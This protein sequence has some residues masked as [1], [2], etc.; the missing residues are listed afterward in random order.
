MVASLLLLTS[1]LLRPTEGACTDQR[2]C[3]RDYDATSRRYTAIYWGLTTVPRDIPR[4]ALELY[5]GHNA[6]ASLPTG[7]FSH[8]TQCRIVRLHDNKKRTVSAGAFDGLLDCVELDLYSNAITSLPAR[9]FAPMP[10]LKKLSL[11]NNQLETIAKESF[12]GLKSLDFLHLGMNRI[13]SIENAVFSEMSSL[14]T[15]YLSN[16][17]LSIIAHGIFTGLHGLQEL[18]LSNPV[19]SV[20]PGALDPLYSLR[21]LTFYSRLTTLT[22]DLFINLPRP[23]LVVGL[24]DNPA[25]NR[26]WDCS[27]LCWLKHEEQHGTVDLGA[28]PGC[29]D[30]EDWF[31]LQCNDPGESG[32]SQGV[33]VSQGGVK[34]SR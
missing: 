31:E 9:V 28:G 14:H 7:V 33:Q 20:E 32:W 10:R 13:S 1:L 8:M 34:G 19:T 24:S 21:W 25:V 5:L 15:L 27:A 29:R 11:F 3:V 16:N 18:H 12:K 30:V 2:Y 4:D 26:Q 23:G 17:R 22:P 6:I